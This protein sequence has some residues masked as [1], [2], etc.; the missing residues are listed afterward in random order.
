[1][2]LLQAREK[3]ATH[4]NANDTAIKA[5]RVAAKQSK[6]AA[7]AADQRLAAAS[8]KAAQAEQQLFDL[9]VCCRCWC[10]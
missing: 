6:A 7:E 2:P 3:V 4:A 8:E 9:Q 5:A 10:A 1:M